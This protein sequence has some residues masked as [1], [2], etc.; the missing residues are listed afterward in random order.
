M[1]LS[2]WLSSSLSL[3]DNI[4]G[5]PPPVHLYTVKI[6][7]F[8]HI[9]MSSLIREKNFTLT[10]FLLE[11]FGPSTISQLFWKRLILTREQHLINSVSLD[12]IN[13]F[14]HAPLHN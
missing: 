5:S 1:E 10:R 8:R 3:Q 4:C 6:E 7:N 9:L 2:D 12:R 13:V 14:I 11:E